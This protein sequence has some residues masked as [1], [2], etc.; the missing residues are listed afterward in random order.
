MNGSG[1]YAC[2]EVK[3]DFDFHLAGLDQLQG[4]CAIFDVVRLRQHEAGDQAL[5]NLL[6]EGGVPVT[7]CFNVLLGKIGSAHS[8]HSIV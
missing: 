6:G 7:N 4:L 1:H 5:L 2:F 8:Q 3:N